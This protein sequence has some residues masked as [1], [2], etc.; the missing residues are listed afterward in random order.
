MRLGDIATA[1]DMHESSISRACSGKYLATRHG[2]FALSRLFRSGMADQQGQMQS[3]DALQ[4]RI[5]ALIAGEDPM[6]PLSD[7]QLV[8]C[9]QAEGMPMARRTVAKYRE[10]LRIAPTNLRKAL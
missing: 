3:M 9:L 1:L 6:Q 7:M 10:A 2:L 4:A 8:A 5:A